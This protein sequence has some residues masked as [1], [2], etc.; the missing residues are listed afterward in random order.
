MSR[1][2]QV[3]TKSNVDVT[4]RRD[5]KRSLTRIQISLVACNFTLVEMKK[6]YR[7]LFGKP[8][9]NRPQGRNMTRYEDNIEDFRPQGRNMTRYEDNIEDFRPQ[10]RN[11]TRYEDNIEDFRP[12]GRNITRYEGNIE[13]LKPKGEI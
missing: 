8:E 3:I 10:G 11:I 1:R 5:V 7:L 9:E 13:D 4:R 6:I 2:R 12:K